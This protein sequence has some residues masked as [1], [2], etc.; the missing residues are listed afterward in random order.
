MPI[1]KHNE[2]IDLVVTKADLWIW[3]AAFIEN[4]FTFLSVTK[5]IP[6]MN[7]TMSE[8]REKFRMIGHCDSE[9]I[10]KIKNKVEVW[11]KIRVQLKDISRIS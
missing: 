7:K 5:E 10:L 4:D 2:L 3:V 8:D 11:E 1:V 6:P 9:T